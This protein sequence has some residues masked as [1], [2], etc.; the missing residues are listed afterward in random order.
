MILN[1]I[2]RLK[3]AGAEFRFYG[4]YD[5]SILKLR[6]LTMGISEMENVTVTKKIG[7][8]GISLVI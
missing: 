3:I 1:E 8:K 5:Y 7:G 2:M 4:G 6:G